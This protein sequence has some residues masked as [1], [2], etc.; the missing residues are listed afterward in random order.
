LI[1]TELDLSHRGGEQFDDGSYL[2]AHKSLLRH[3]PQHGDFRKKFHLPHLLISKNI[4][5]NKPRRNFAR[6]DNPTTPNPGSSTASPQFKV[7]NVPG[8]ELIGSSG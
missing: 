4:A 6:Q 7:Y 5:P 8:S 3:V 2:A 1:V